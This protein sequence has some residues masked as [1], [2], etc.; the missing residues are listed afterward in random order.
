MTT[1]ESRQ[2]E[3]VWAE[4]KDTSLDFESIKVDDD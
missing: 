1:I 3:T 4:S 2:T